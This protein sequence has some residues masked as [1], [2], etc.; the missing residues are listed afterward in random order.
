MQHDVDVENPFK[1]PPRPESDSAWDELLRGEFYALIDYQ[2]ALS[3]SN[4]FVARHSAVLPSELGDQLSSVDINDGSGHV[5]VE[6]DVFHNLDCLNSIRK[7]LHRTYYNESTSKAMAH[8]RQVDTCIDS[9]RQSLMCHGDIAI[10]TYVW[11]KDH[12]LPWPDFNIMHECRK[13]DNIQAWA[14]E[15]QAPDLSGDMLMH[16]TFGKNTGLVLK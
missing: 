14:V 6:L 10:G 1:G 4:D 9:I 11:K 12:L 2:N 7:Y 15:H 3:D 16:P 8:L 13:W 5:L